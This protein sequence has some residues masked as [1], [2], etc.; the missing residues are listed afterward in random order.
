MQKILGRI[1]TSSNTKYDLVSVIAEGRTGIVCKATSLG[2][3]DIAVKVYRKI[4]LVGYPDDFIE[5]SSVNER[6]I[7]RQT[8]MFQSFVKFV[9]EVKIEY[10]ND[11]EV[12]GMVG[13]VGIQSPVLAIANAFEYVNA[14][15]LIKALSYGHISIED[16]VKFIQ[17]T[18]VGVKQLHD[19]EIA[20]CDL[21]RANILVTKEKI[22]RIIDLALATPFGLIADAAVDSTFAAA[23]EARKIP[24]YK[25]SAPEKF[26]KQP[27]DGRVDIYS[28]GL[29]ILFS[30]TVIPSHSR[31]RN[32]HLNTKED[33]WQLV[34]DRFCYNKKLKQAVLTATH[35]D[36]TKRYQNSIDF[37]DALE[38]AG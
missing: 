22:P 21:M 11:L 8:A 33:Y 17:L 13:E 25:F 15:S 6:N 2:N 20:H 14:P 32:F 19:I 24:V 1:I 35:P 3:D 38:E 34:P 37:A 23:R 30:L 31:I 26:T 10:L 28:L 7:G 4:N 5:K 9:D 27:L 18:A 16:I 12:F 29:A 36:P